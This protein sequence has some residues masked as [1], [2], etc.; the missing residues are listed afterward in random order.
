MRAALITEL[1]G[2]VVAGRIALDVET[3]PL[4]SVGKAWAR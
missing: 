4:D 3:L 1:L 2:H